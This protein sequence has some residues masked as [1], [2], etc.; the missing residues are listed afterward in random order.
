M[1]RAAEAGITWLLGDI[2][3]HLARNLIELDR[4]ADALGVLDAQD[5]ERLELAAAVQAAALRAKALLATG[6]R[7]MAARA[8]EDGLRLA[9]EAELVAERAE[10]YE[11]RGMSRIGSRNGPRVAAAERDLAHAVALYLAAGMTEKARELSTR[12][13][14]S[15]GM[16]VRRGGGFL[17]DQP[18]LPLPEPKAERIESRTD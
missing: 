14:P 6:R 15:P 2:S 5:P 3:N 13:L 18:T 11:M 1:A 9:A 16:H 10:L 12:F 8:A 7:T 4:P 17:S